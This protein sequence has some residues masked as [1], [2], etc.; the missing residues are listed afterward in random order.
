MSIASVSSSPAGLT[1]VAD[2]APGG[3][4]IVTPGTVL[5]ANALDQRALLFVDTTVSPWTVQSSL[6]R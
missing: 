3:F 1:P 2:K 5:D 4:A 6:S